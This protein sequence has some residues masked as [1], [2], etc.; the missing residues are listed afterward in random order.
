MS[1]S[2]FSAIGCLLDVDVAVPGDER[3]MQARWLVTAVATKLLD[4]RRRDMTARIN[5]CWGRMQDMH[6]EIWPGIAVEDSIQ[7]M[8]DREGNQSRFVQPLRF[9][10]Y[11][12]DCFTCLVHNID[13]FLFLYLF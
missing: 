12:N 5:E 9:Q 8:C 1:T 7:I 11:F 3:A 6:N 10:N 2:S 13:I 4:C